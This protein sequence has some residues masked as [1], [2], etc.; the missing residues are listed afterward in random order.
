MEE[1]GGGG[2]NFKIKRG[3]CLELRATC[4]CAQSCVCVCVCVVTTTTPCTHTQV[5]LRFYY[6]YNKSSARCPIHASILIRK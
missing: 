1:E 2:S 5:Y 4:V 6:M 3:W